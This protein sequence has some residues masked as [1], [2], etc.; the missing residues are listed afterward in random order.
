MKKI[1]IALAA[2]LLVVSSNY[3]I[4]AVAEY[5]PFKVSNVRIGT[6]GFFVQLTPAPVSCGGGDHYRMHAKV[7]YTSLSALSGTKGRNLTDTSLDASLLGINKEL[8]DKLF[9]AYTEGL[10]LDFIW[11]QNEGTCSDDYGDI[12]DLY[13][14]EFSK[15]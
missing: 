12:L 13:M 2:L 3:A 1:R 4:A 9:T 15:K 11:V 6:E 14:I 5:G 10:S 8:I 7:P